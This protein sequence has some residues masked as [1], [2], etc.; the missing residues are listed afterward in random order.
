VAYN[1]LIDCDKSD[2]SMWANSVMA[3]NFIREITE[4]REVRLRKLIDKPTEAHAES[5][6]AFDKILS[7]IEE[8]K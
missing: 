8:A 4:L 6:K 3:K 7:L 2:M 5:V 1:K